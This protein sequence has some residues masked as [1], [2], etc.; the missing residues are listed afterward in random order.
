MDCVPGL[1]F[2]PVRKANIEK[3]PSAMFLF[4]KYKILQVQM[5]CLLR[6]KLADER[7]M[8]LLDKSRNPLEIQKCLSM[9]VGMA[10]TPC[11][12]DQ[13]IFLFIGC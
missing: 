12:I 9:R 7:G 5:S 2:R 11:L 4:R 8:D 13:Y 3:N 10:L 1:R 6:M